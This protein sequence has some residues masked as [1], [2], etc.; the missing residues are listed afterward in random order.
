MNFTALLIT[1]VS[2]FLISSATGLWLIP[3]LRRLH[4]GQTILDIGPA[5]HKSKQGTPTMGGLMMVIGLIVSVLAGWATLHLSGSGIADAS[6]GGS[7]YLFGGVLMALGFGLLG[8]LDD[9]IKVVKKRNLGLKAGQKSLGQL[10]VAV[11]YLAAEYIF[12]PHTTLWIPFA[13]EF[14]I[15]FFYYPVM[16]FI[17]IGA[18]NAVNLTDGIDGLASSVT[19]VAAMGFLVISSIEGFVQMNLLAAALAGVCLGFL[20]WNFHPAKVFMGD[21]GSLALGG[22]VSASAF[23]MQIPLFIPIIG[24]IYLVEVLSVIMQVSYFKATHGKRIFRMAPIHHHFELGGWS[25]TRVV[26]VFSIVTALLCLVAYL[27]L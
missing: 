17:I 24:L 7:F 22:F 11:L 12:A 18:V 10:L 1:L 23:M 25:E 27:G 16:L 13:G 5:W 4:Y 9:Y 20:V 19:M 8:F 21:T 6:E 3:F 26:A 2:A 15:G 14:D